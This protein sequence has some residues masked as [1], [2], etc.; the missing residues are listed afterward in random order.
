M[1]PSYLT[2]VVIQYGIGVVAF[3]DISGFTK[4]SEKL[5]K[6]HGSAGAELLNKFISGYFDKLIRV[7]V[8]FGGEYV[9]FPRSSP[10][11]MFYNNDDVGAIIVLLNSLVMPC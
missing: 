1:P 4:L 9:P 6:E 8:D 2:Y 3:V 10:Y 5:V 11:V 7:V